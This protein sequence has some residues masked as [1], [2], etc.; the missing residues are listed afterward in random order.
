VLQ[1]KPHI[2][3]EPAPIFGIASLGDSFITLSIQP[4]V[5]VGDFDVAWTEGYQSLLERFQE[6]KIEIPSSRQAVRLINQSS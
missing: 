5:S 6:K 4:W 1:Q 2:L 3:K